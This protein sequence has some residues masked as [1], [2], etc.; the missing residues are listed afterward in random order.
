MMFSITP[1]DILLENTASTV[2][3]FG[4]VSFESRCLGSLRLLKTHGV[5]ISRA[6][7]FD[8]PTIMSPKTKG[9]QDRA[10]NKNEIRELLGERVEFLLTHPHRYAEFIGGINRQVSRIENT[11]K[12][13]VLIFDISCLTR[14]HALALSYWALHANCCYP[15]I[16]AYSSPAYYG[17][18]SKSIWGKGAWLYTILM[19]LD[20]ESTEM[21]SS[22]KALIILGHEGD[23]LRLALSELE[24]DSGLIFTTASRGRES[25]VIAAQNAWLYK[26]INSG[27]R[28]SYLTSEA[29]LGG[30]DQFSRLILDFCEKAKYENSRIVLCPFGPK[31]LVFLAG[32][33]CLSHLPLNT[34]LSYPIPKAYDPNY[35]NGHDSTYWYSLL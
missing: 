10:D 17:S 6:I 20:L 19:R 14:I 1:P 15:I 22:T 24:A 16:L 34:W 32:Y 5:G 11:T 18:L 21:F 13:A 29:G 7:A 35:S 8:Y 30:T 27:M 28:A 23:R 2:I 31:S 9:E 12:N 33:I 3:W 25:T 4:A 26:E